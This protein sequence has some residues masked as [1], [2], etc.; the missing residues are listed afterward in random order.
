MHA[1]GTY[2]C[3]SSLECLKKLVL[4]VSS[5]QAS[6]MGWALEASIDWE[7]VGIVVEEAEAGSEL[8]D[9]LSGLAGAFAPDR[10]ELLKRRIT[11]SCLDIRVLADVFLSV[12]HTIYKPGN[13][14]VGE[15]KAVSVIASS[16]IKGY[17]DPLVV[18]HRRVCEHVCPNLALRPSHVTHDLEVQLYPRMG[19][20]F[21]VQA[22]IV[23]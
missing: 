16:N 2:L 18:L 14:A 12:G 4:A 23:R 21:V 9:T 7:A 8:W 6:A 11:H 19:L 13:T 3:S 1:S 5:S 20:R 10:S 22:T 17:C 15:V